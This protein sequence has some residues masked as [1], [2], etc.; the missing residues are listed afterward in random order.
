M[1]PSCSQYAKVAFS[2]YHALK[3]WVITTDRLFRCGHD[4]RGYEK[5]ALNDQWYILDPVS[6]TYRPNNALIRLGT[7]ESDTS[8]SFADYLYEKREF[9]A[10]IENYFRLIYE[11]K[12]T[13]NVDYYLTQIGLSYYHLENHDQLKRHFLE[14]F[15]QMQPFYRNKL[16]LYLTKSFYD[17][18][19]YEGMKVSLNTLINPSRNHQN[20]KYYLLGLADLGQTNYED[21][22]NHMKMVDSDSEYHVVAKRFININKEIDQ[23]PKRSPVFAGLSSAIIPGSGY[24]ISN[25]PRTAFSAFLLNGLLGW[26]IYSSFKNDHIALG[27]TIAVFTGGWYFGAIRGSSRAVKEW[28]KQQEINLINDKLSY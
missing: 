10:A 1:Y 16:A 18:N 25:K 28:N 13:T 22:S 20:F 26:A 8:K 11:S 15:D 14:N 21:A 6:K 23:L 2:E 3:A 17:Q 7:I 27:T 4:L 12:D 19:D 5:I 9:N 24:L